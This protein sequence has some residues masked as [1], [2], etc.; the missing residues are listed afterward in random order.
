MDGM[1]AECTMGVEL[2]EYLVLAV[3]CW[4]GVEETWGRRCYPVDLVTFRL[5]S[6]GSLR[7]AAIDHH[8]R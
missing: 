5:S 8:V 3:A 4:D 6:H 7:A 2:G 1:Q